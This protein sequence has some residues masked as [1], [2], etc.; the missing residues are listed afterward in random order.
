[1]SSISSDTRF[2]R[3]VSKL[4]TAGKLPSSRLSELTRCK[5]PKSD[6]IIDEI[7]LRTSKMIEYALKFD[8]TG[9]FA[10]DYG[11]M[12]QMMSDAVSQSGV[13]YTIDRTLS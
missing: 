2:E 4:M 6:E 11:T 5:C 12:S 3:F 9:V 10:F 7:N 13:G 1:M 8:K